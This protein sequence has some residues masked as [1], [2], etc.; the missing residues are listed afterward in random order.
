MNAQM[1]Q[2]VGFIC[3]R[4]VTDIADEGLLSSLT[5]SQTGEKPFVTDIADEGLLSSL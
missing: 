4:A 2:Q 5:Y 1:G 3:K